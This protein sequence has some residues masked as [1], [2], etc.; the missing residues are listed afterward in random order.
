M[1]SIH[2]ES[3][4][5]VS[6]FPE[7]SALVLAMDRVQD[8]CNAI[9]S[10]RSAE[11]I[12]TRQPL[13]TVTLYGAGSKELEA[14]AALIADETNIK[15]V[16]F[17]DDLEKVAELK[18]KINFPALGKR[19][20]E[21]MKD[22]I[23]ASK[24]G[25]W[26]QN[27]AGAIEILGEALTEEEC[28]L[29]LEPKDKNGAAALSTNDALV[30]LDTNITPELHLE[31]IARDMVR[32]IQQARKD[33]DLHISDRI[34]LAVEAVDDVAKAIDAHKS[35]IAEQ[36]LASSLEAVKINGQKHIS[37][38]ELEGKPVKIGFSVAA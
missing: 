35:Y 13:G 22:I 3:F 24:K 21:K 14:H 32:L 26:K 15:A 4:P 16:A 31:G 36:T 25:E 18:L 5:D 7:D 1:K 38:H 20:P 9:H 10:V 33:A 27:K 29:K 37:E 12:R 17:S 19:L 23:A 30:V 11:N 8:A 2:L 6:G 28:S 34:A